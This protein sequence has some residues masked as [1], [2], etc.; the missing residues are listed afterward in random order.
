MNRV[1]VG[2]VRRADERVRGWMT[3][4]GQCVEG[5]AWSRQ[6]GRQNSHRSDGQFRAGEPWPLTLKFV[7]LVQTLLMG[8]WQAPIGLFR[9]ILFP[10]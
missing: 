7:G 5:R 2:E 10:E 4:R 9:S 1:N 6:K 3:A 8:T